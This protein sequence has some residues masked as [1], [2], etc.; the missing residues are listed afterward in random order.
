MRM[1]LLDPALLLTPVTL[2]QADQLAD[3]RSAYAW[4]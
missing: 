4:S 2:Q 3:Q 1:A